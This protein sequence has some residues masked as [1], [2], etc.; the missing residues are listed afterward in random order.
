MYKSLLHGK[1]LLI[2]GGST[3]KAA[4]RK[5]ADENGIFVIAAAPY[6]VGIFEIADESYIIDVT[7]HEKMKAFIK[8]HRIDGVYMGGA[9]PVIE[10]AC[11]YI[12]ELGF[13]CYCTKK[14]WDALQNKARFKELCTLHGLPIVPQYVL[15]TSDLANSVPIESYPVITKPTDGFGSNGFYVCQTP[16]ELELGYK[17]AAAASPTGSVICE[18][19]VNNESV[20][21]FV[22]FSKG[23]TL[24]CGLEEKIPIRYEEERSYVG[25]IYLFESCLVKDFK[26]RFM[27]KIES[28]FSS[29]G[30]KEGN[31]W[32]EV[33][34]DN[35]EYFFNEVGFRYGGSISVFPV[36]YFYHI[37]QVA[38]DIYYALTGRSCVFGHSS[39]IPSNF[40]RKQYYC[41]YPVHAKTGTIATIY[42][43]EELESMS[44]IVIVNI[45]KGLGST[46][47]QTGSFSQV[48]SLVHFVFDDLDECKGTI[49]KIHNTLK[50]CDIEGNNLIVRKLDESSIRFLAS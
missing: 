14:Q 37:N 18:R 45:N 50:I 12:N 5:Y 24:F 6:S 40:K 29:L 16:D 38:S 35:G 7:N 11:Q 9:E 36:D 20:G 42:G 3:W 33:F 49:N 43:V 2:L 34:Y 47:I 13:P 25:G 17:K 10:S 30:I 22:T 28:L 31:A 44:E 48:V 46:I 26:Q 19:F 27:H 21:L 8:E 4:I 1:R 15:N 41:A 39:L 32:I 23:K